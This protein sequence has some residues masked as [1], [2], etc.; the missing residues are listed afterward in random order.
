MT[1]NNKRKPIV[2]PSKRLP[3]P[4]AMLTTDETATFLGVQPKTLANQRSLGTGPAFHKW[5]GKVW[6]SGQDIIAYRNRHRYRGS[7]LRDEG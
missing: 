7:G 1:K 3:H 5:C 6:Y 2:R 4:K